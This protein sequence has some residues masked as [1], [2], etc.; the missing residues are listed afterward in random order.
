MLLA[1]LVFPLVLGVLALGC[2][3]L[4]EQAAGVKLPG[5][6]LLPAGLSLVVVAAGLAT[7]TGATAQ[8]AVPAVVGLAVA[9]LALSLPWY[10]RRLDVWAL[11]AAGGVFAVFAAPV[12]LS[13]QAT[14]AGWI[15]LDDGATWL[16]LTD[17]LMQY[18]RSVAGLPHSTY[19]VTLEANL[20]T[21]YP[22]GAFMPLGVGGRLLGQDIAWLIQPYEAFLA[23][24][25]A[26]V[27]YALSSRVLAS[28]ALRALAAFVAAQAALFYGYALWGGIKEVAAA[29]LIAL[30]AALVPLALDAKAAARA[31]VPLGVA[32]AA[33]VGAL[34]LGGS[35]WLVPIL[36]PVLWLATRRR[37]GRLTLKAAAA[38]AAVAIVLAIPTLATTQAFASAA[39]TSSALTSGKELGNLIDPLR[40]VQVVGIWPTGDFRTGPEH[41]GPT[42]ALIVVAAL[43]AAVGVVHGLRRGSPELPLYVAS[44]LFGSVVL[45]LLGSP[46]VAGKALAT[47]SPALVAAAAVGGGALVEGGRRVEGSFAMLA[48]AGGVLWSN[49]LAYHDAW[50]APKA[51]LA[52]LAS[53]GHRFAGQGP[54]L[55]MEYSPYGVRHFLRTL[56][57]EA[58]GEFRWRP[59]PLRNG[60]EVPKGGYADIDEVQTSAVLVYRTLVLNRSP[61]ASRPPSVYRL[62]WRGRYYEVWQRPAALTTRIVDHLPLG[63]GD[64]AASVPS[65]A[66]VLRLARE[67][68]RAGGVLA[69]V[70]RA[71]ATVLPL[72]QAFVPSGWATDAGS[73]DVVYPNRPGTLEAAVTLAAAAQYEVWIGGSF[74]RRLEVWVDGQRVGQ[75]VHQLTHPGVYTPMGTLR[76]TSGLHEV[77]LQY[78][79]AD[80]RPGSGGPALPLGPVVLGR[81]TAEL[82]V[83]SVKPADARSLCGKSLDWVEA[84][85]T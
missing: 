14:F 66:A 77:V 47:A 16:A 58:A 85:G 3:L 54:A 7:M 6:L 74:R 41:R 49:T 12:V 53:I 31:V 24:M 38:L 32:I 11:A 27:V 62:V 37:G 57:P 59:I 8:L 82:A 73:P 52:E 35:L 33:T 75:A 61:V 26:F 40:F 4:L 30:T 20:G 63:G 15:K 78:S 69:A 70:L 50:L 65:C 67:A 17:R 83:T 23:A 84:V 80:L 72:S 79:A 29:P 76:L 28:R 44:A 13:G 46:W 68:D 56:D 34:T 42:Y 22:V 1:W 10:G 9:G 43:A 45:T 60:G 51:P 71:P 18:G 2:G 81:T 55:M 64:Q 25:L 36:L 39:S 5:A 48:I 19:Q 21:G